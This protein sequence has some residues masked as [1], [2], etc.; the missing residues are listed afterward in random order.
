MQ[1]RRTDL[2]WL[3]AG[4]LPL[5]GSIS[6]SAARLEVLVSSASVAPGDPL[7][8]SV[9]GDSEGE[10][11]RIAGAILLYSGDVLPSDA[12]GPFELLTTNPD[13]LW[14]ATPLMGRCG[15]A[16]DPASSCRAVDAFTDPSIRSDL[17]P[18]TLTIFDFDTSSALPGTLLT[19]QAVPT[20][21]GFF[22]A[23]PSEVVTVQV[24][25]EPASALL[26]ALGVLAAAT[27]ASYRRRATA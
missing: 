18:G 13:A 19:F 8:V 2:V 26:V 5:L 1:R 4:M 16:E 9:L 20:S 24:I 27:E 3:L 25:P 22:G 23:G 12:T 7:S 17:L 10:T 21:G 15:L 14:F 6:A 11:S